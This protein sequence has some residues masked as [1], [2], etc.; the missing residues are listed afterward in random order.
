MLSF[1]FLAK[2][3]AEKYWS[4]VNTNSS[5]TSTQKTTSLTDTV[6]SG[7]EYTV[8]TQETRSWS[9]S[10]SDKAGWYR[11][12][13]F[14]ASDV[15]LYVIRDRTK[16]KEIYYEFR[17]HV[18]P[19]VY[20]WQLDYL[21]T[22]SFSKSDETRFGFDISWLD[23]LPKTKSGNI[24]PLFEVTFNS[25]G[26]SSVAKQTVLFNGTVTK[27]T[28]PTMS[29]CT[30]AGWYRDSGFKNLYDFSTKVIE[31]T[32]LYAKWTATVTFSVNS[33]SGTAPASQTVSTG[34]SI[35][36]P[37]GS[38]L[39][40]SGNIFTGWNTNASGTGTTYSAGSSFPV[41]SNVTLYA[42]WSVTSFSKEEVEFRDN[43]F[44]CR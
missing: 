39:S 14:S 36:L 10:K 4:D 35:T 41:S 21:E 26:G 6:K 18:I 24:A 38:G 37:S 32:T 2:V 25:N 34:T 20:F 31:N 16:P 27:P 28:N 43:I 13:L 23:N 9:F 1:K 15:Y 12:T 44:I 42:K 40:K 22:A 17:E 33:G 11:Y 7:T 3:A 8:S 5:S 19:D 30:F 29:G